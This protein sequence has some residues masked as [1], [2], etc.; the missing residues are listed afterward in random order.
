MHTLGQATRI[1]RFQVETTTLGT[2]GRTYV[3]FAVVGEDGV[4]GPVFGEISLEAA[5][6]TPVVDLY[7]S[8]GYRLGRGPVPPSEVDRYCLDADEL[9]DLHEWAC[10]IASLQD[11]D[12]DAERD[13]DDYEPATGDVI[14]GAVG[15]AVVLAAMIGIGFG[16]AKAIRFV[17]RR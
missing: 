16:V 1:G 7:E 13:S 2:D 8:A 10:A 17:S 4:P 15:L 11:G 9:A 3:A 12:A 6:M 14:L 5:C